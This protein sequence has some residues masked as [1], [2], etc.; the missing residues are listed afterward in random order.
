[1]EGDSVIGQNQCIWA[2]GIG[3]GVVN[4]TGHGD[5]LTGSIG[6]LSG[7]HGQGQRD[8]A[9]EEW[10]KRIGQ[11]LSPAVVDTSPQEI[12]AWKGEAERGRGRDRGGE[13]AIQIYDEGA[14][15]VAAAALG[16][17]LGHQVAPPV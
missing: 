2:D 7:V 16:R 4:P 5:G 12:A 17:G 6:R 15:V 13:A 11:D 9:D 8:V 10:I 14:K 3:S 1:M